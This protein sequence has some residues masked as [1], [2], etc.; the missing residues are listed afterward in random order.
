MHRLAMRFALPLCL[1]VCACLHTPL[2]A[3]SITAGQPQK[4]GIDTFALYKAGGGFGVSVDVDIKQADTPAAK[5]IKIKE[6]VNQTIAGIASI[7]NNDLTK[8][9][10]AGYNALIFGNKSREPIKVADAG[11]VGVTGNVAYVG[12]NADPSGEDPFGFESSFTTSFGYVGLSISATLLYHQLSGPTIDDLL[13]DMYYDL[14][15]Q[16]PVTLQPRISLGPRFIRFDLPDDQSGYFVDNL[17]TDTVTE[18]LGGLATVPEPSTLVLTAAGCLVLLAVRWRTRW[19]SLEERI[20]D[21]A[22]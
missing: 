13:T 10:L 5:A 2:H 8:V 6:A 22:S 14:R 19:A 9:N 20:A 16:L 18:E 12:Y 21:W 11:G 4:D 15:S 1:L 17:S 3:G 7:D